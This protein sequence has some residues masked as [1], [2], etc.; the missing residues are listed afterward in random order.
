MICY[1]EGTLSLPTARALPPKTRG[2]ARPARGAAPVQRIA[3]E[4]AADVA[5]LASHWKR[6][7]REL[8]A[9]R[10]TRFVLAADPLDWLQF[11]WG[12]SECLEDLRS[13]VLG[14]TYSPS[15]PEF[16]RAAKTMGLT[17]PVAFLRP[18]D[19]LLYK[20]LVALADVDLM[21]T[22]F[23]WTRFG[24]SDSRQGDQ[25]PDPES[26]W[27]RAWLLRNGQLWTI[28]TGNVWIVETD[29]SNFFPSIQLDLA[30]SHVLANSRLSVEAVR[31]LSYM[32]RGFAPQAEY[33]TNPVVGLPQD[34]FDCSRIIAHSF[35]QSVDEEFEVEGAADRYSRYMDDI[36]LGA[37]TFED[38]LRLVGRAQRSLEKIGLYPN[39]A[40]T[41]L[42]RADQ[43]AS[44]LMKDENDYLGDVEDALHE[45]DPVDLPEFRRRLRSHLRLDPQPRA[46]ERVLRRYYTLSRRL[47]DKSLIDKAA[48]HI[49]QY[50][51][52]SRWVLDY[53]STFE[54][55]TGRVDSVLAVVDGLGDLYED[56]AL[57]A[58]QYLAVSPNRRSPVLVAG[59]A[60]RALAALEKA[61]E[62]P[63]LGAAAAVVV[64]KYGDAT[65][66]DRLELLYETEVERDGN[67]LRR[68]LAIIL[69]ATGRL[70]LKEV[71]RIA[72][73][74]EAAARTIRFLSALGAK[75]QRAMDLTIGALQP[76][77]RKEPL[78]YMV[79]PRPMFLAPL[80]AAVDAPRLARVRKGWT[81]RVRKSGAGRD[82]TGEWWLGI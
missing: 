27:F 18:E 53:L 43:F 6:L 80:L 5:L 81:R 64:G 36:V 3:L 55:S 41:K 77:E 16:I 20:N 14:G 79:S 73:E 40:K 54:L 52:S 45:G 37:D 74:S 70:S 11:E 56:L 34:L 7:R 69:L 13:A 10:V 48:A 76:K 39:A 31:L 44:G 78:M 2:G 4:R 24:R 8:Q 66:V 32:L 59:I 23:H 71:A 25:H 63:R 46:W 17:R 67:V 19:L 51:G 21:S 68:Q 28:T 29:I 12:L 58:M 42:I 75:N 35:L 9:P 22:M 65:H 82:R 33:R 1:R 57:L 50:P 62:R 38:G 49:R 15:R 61:L 30:A 60:T 72:T 26:G 47:R